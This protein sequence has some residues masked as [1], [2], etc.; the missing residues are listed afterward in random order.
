MH[1]HN[2]AKIVLNAR[3]FKFSW[4]KKHLFNAKLSRKW[5]VLAGTKSKE[6]GEEGDYT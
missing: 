1:R 5:S 2:G 6:M 4:F 3:L